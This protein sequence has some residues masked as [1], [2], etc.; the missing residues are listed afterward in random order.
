M[1]Y[2]TRPDERSGRRIIEATRCCS[3]HSRLFRVRACG[4]DALVP[5]SLRVSAPQE[6][7]GSRF[8]LRCGMSDVMLILEPSATVRISA[9][10][11]VV[12]WFT[13]LKRRTQNLPT[14]IS[15]ITAR[16]LLRKAIACVWIWAGHPC[17]SLS[18]ACRLSRI[19]L[20]DRYPARPGAHRCRGGAS[21]AHRE[22][23]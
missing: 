4:G 23:Q 8:T 2:E 5:Q 17:S 14:L 3:S 21:D 7:T 1:P 22:P 12:G 20:S 11:S 16:S 19:G 10:D 13:R 9:A 6:G 15:N 18:S